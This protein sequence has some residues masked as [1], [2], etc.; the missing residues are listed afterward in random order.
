MDAN[1][2]L[3]VI[4][5]LQKKNYWNLA[6]LKQYVLDKYNVR[7]ASEQ[8]YYDLFKAAGISWKKTQQCNPKLKPELVEKKQ[9]ITN[10]LN[11]RR[12]QIESGELVVLFGR[13]LSNASGEMSA[14]TCGVRQ[15]NALKFQ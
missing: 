9:E 3:E 10:W 15:T 13:C 14:D 8:S 7:F 12:G 5:W 4:E 2:R 6:E 1:A 11:A